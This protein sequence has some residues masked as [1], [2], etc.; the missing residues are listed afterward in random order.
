LS[1]PCD[2]ELKKVVAK[3]KK[4]IYN[5]KRLEKTSTFLFPK[6]K[7]IIK[8]TYM[9]D[10]PNYHHHL[11]NA[12]FGPFGYGGYGGGFAQ[13]GQGGYGSQLHQDH[14]DI[15]HD[16]GCARKEVSEVGAHV[17]GDIGTVRME[18][19]G[20]TAEVRY[21]IG[22]V[23]KEQ[24]EQSA[25]I[26]HEVAV[27]SCK[28]NDNIKE[29]AFKNLSATDAVG[30]RLTNQNDQH[31][32]TTSAQNW[33]IARDVIQTRGALEQGQTAIKAAI[34]YSSDKNALNADLYHTKTV[35]EL[36]K[37]QAVLQDK[38]AFEGNETR[39]LINEQKYG[40]LNRALIER[41]AELVGCQAE[42]CH[43]RNNVDQ[44]QFASMNN[45][46]Q[47][48][49]S[50]LQDTRQSMVNFGTMAGGSGKQDST[51]NNVR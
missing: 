27:E 41:N 47:A 48:F 6:I 29:S 32:T 31:F 44:V 11:H 8:E 14:S 49:Q 24:A 5:I 4:V 40:D 33:D 26:R 42:K 1:I 28:I 38:I 39:K 19:A 23:R 21:N 22:D 17:R 35:V 13:G 10:T 16:I 34:D 43:W 50:Q 25:S 37:A 3:T 46:L 30:D 51:S 18:S 36:A 45:M 20:Q 2:I 12:G 15:R 9:T 7:I